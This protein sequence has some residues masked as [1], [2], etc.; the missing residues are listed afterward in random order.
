MPLGRSQA[1]GVGPR[2]ALNFNFMGEIL[3][4]KAFHAMGLHLIVHE[5]VR[6]CV[7]KEMTFEVDLKWKIEV[8]T[9]NEG[10]KTAYTKSWIDEGTWC[11]VVVVG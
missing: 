6:K 2:R 7:T 3:Y 1:N 9:E 10:R 5:G 4:R 11:L 8:C